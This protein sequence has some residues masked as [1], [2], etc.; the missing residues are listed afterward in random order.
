M[1]LNFSNHLKV[2]LL[3][4]PCIQTMID[5]SVVLFSLNCGNFLYLLYFLPMQSLVDQC[6]SDDIDTEVNLGCLLFQVCIGLLLA[7]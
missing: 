1:F 6:S 5:S 3:Y 2:K 4:L 7:N